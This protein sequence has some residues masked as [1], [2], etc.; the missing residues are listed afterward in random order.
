M[1]DIMAGASAPTMFTL[2]TEAAQAYREHQVA[3]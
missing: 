3:M 1:V 2:F